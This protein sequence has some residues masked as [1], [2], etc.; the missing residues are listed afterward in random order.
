MALC[1][2][3]LAHLVLRRALDSRLFGI[4]FAKIV[5]NITTLPTQQWRDEINKSDDEEV[6]DRDCSDDQQDIRDDCSRYG[7]YIS[8]WDESDAN[9]PCCDASEAH[10]DEDKV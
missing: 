5:V 2:L 6:D 4:F 9:S 10:E 8:C 7:A 1:C 3:L